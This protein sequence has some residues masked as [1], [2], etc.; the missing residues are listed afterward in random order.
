MIQ[1]PEM[2]E[3]DI[4]KWV[5]DTAFQRGYR[6]FENEA[7]LNPRRRGSSLISECQGSQLTPYRVEINLG[8]E[9]ILRGTCTYPAGDGGYCST[10][11]P[12]C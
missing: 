4:K 8:P 11:P 7:I 6:Y 3:S 2:G 12:C 5:G 9:G 10:P 1:L